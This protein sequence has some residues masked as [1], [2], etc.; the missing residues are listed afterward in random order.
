MNE[1]GLYV[2]LSQQE[3][4]RMG[5]VAR[6][7]LIP[8]PQKLIGGTEVYQKE[9][10]PYWF[11]RI[12]GGRD[13]FMHLYTEDL[14][15]HDVLYDDYEDEFRD[16]NITHNTY[17]FKDE[18]LQC[19]EQK[20]E[21]G[22]VWIPV[23]EPSSDGNDEIQ[24]VGEETP[25]T[26]LSAI[27]W[28]RRFEVYSPE[29]ESQMAQKS[30]GFLLLLRWLKDGMSDIVELAEDSGNIG[31]YLYYGQEE[32]LEMTGERFFGGLAG[33]VGNTVKIMKVC[34]PRDNRRTFYQTSGSYMSFSNAV[35]RIHLMITGTYDFEQED[36]VG[37]MELRK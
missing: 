8:K 3:N 23:Y 1:K 20:P 4:C 11:C 6:E 9:G 29:N 35:G 32:K 28:E 25:L 13:E 22:F 37:L 26:G 2:D 24:F 21:N 33:F 12:K 15:R 30:T 14:T 10:L 31:H 18:L 5:K 7:I 16:Y 19:V 34:D 36:A 17:K 27:E